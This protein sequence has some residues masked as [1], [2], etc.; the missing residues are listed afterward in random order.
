M[1]TSGRMTAE[2]LIHHTKQDG[3]AAYGRDCGEGRDIVIAPSKDSECDRL[4]IGNILSSETTV[5]ATLD[6]GPKPALKMALDNLMPVWN[7]ARRGN[8]FIA[9]DAPNM[10]ALSDRFITHAIGDFTKQKLPVGAIAPHAMQALHDDVCESLAIVRDVIDGDAPMMLRMMYYP[11]ASQPLAIFHHWHADTYPSNLMG[12][13][14]LQRSANHEGMRFAFKEQAGDVLQGVGLSTG[15]T[16]FKVTE[17]N[18]HS[19]AP[20]S[21]TI[22]RMMYTITGHPLSRGQSL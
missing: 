17:E 2:R 6:N 3:Y 7:E 4:F 12:K 19:A 5:A 15:R 9:L 14:R 18:V 20:V 8:A 1:V 11:P 22:G 21:Q 16:A 13:L 10:E